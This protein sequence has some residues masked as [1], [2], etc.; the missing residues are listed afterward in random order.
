MYISQTQRL[1][2]T[3]IH[4][5]IFRNYFLISSMLILLLVQRELVTEIS[6]YDI[7]EILSKCIRLTFILLT[8]V[9]ALTRVVYS[10][11]IYKE[12]KLFRRQFPY[13][14]TNCDMH[15]SDESW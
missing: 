6:L 2:T 4:S 14:Q 8:E 15:R 9:N 13:T 11:H 5:L 12:I 3:K 10:E 1:I 7:P